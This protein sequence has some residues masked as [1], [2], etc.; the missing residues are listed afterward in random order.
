MALGIRK[1]LFILTISI[2]IIAVATAA[3]LTISIIIK[4]GKQTAEEYRQEEMTRVRN[5]VRDYIEMAYQSVETSYKSIDDKEYLEKF[6]GHRLQSIMDIAVA[7]LEKRAQQ[8]D[9]HKLTLREAQRQAIDEIEAM[10]FDNR[11]GYIWVNDTTLPYPKMIMHPTVP[12]L[13]GNYLTDPKFNCAMGKNQNLFQ[14]AVEV[15]TASGSGFV[16]Y[17]WP[18][19]NA[20]GLS[21]DVK[22]LSYVYHFKPWGWVLGTGI[23]LDDAQND[24]VNG[25]LENLKTLKYNNGQ[26]YFWVN[27]MELPYPRMVMHPTVPS[28]DGK[29]LNDTSFNCAKGT[30]QNFFQLMVQKATKDGEG[31]V[32]YI[33]PNPVTKK[34][35]AKL[36]YVKRFAPLNWMIG[37][38]AFVNHIES[39]IQAK[40]NEI[41]G[42]VRNIIWITLA[43]SVVLIAIG[44]FATAY[45]ANS[46]THAIIVVRDSLLKLSKGKIIDKLDVKSD[47]EIGVMNASLNSLVDG[48]NAYATFAREIGTGNLDAEFK[49]LSEDD[50]L[51][52]SLIQM[53]ESL[54]RI[55]Q[56]EFERK[57]HAEGVTFFNDL[58]RKHNDNLKE[59][60]NHLVAQAARY[61]NANQC[62]L[63]L[64][65]ADRITDEPYLE[66]YACYA[67]DRNKHLTQRIAIGE[68]VIGQAVI[69]KNYIYLTQVPK[70]FVRITSGLGA[71][72]PT[73]VIIFPLIYNEEVQ[74]VIEI[75]SF[76][77]LKPYE[78]EFLRKV[79]ESIAASISSTKTA[80]RTRMLLEETKQMSEEMKA[81]EEELRQNNE[82]LQATQEE[83]MRKLSESERS[84]NDR[85]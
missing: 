53:R 28:L 33:W 47:N 59:L 83:M 82:E 5:S 56:E 74:G 44:Y 40:E 84:K 12:A 69:E 61:L 67:Y 31:Y 30:G 13:N 14:A 85:P 16:N 62:A 80:E 46:I 71:A 43:I 77:K 66:L 54:K 32:E 75:A 37:T 73:A 27:D 68:G 1:Q 24:V 45:M 70:D 41:Q 2:L 25:I 29:I 39:R 65:E 6:Y 51:G 79:S 76:E 21:Q 15:S 81:Q 10:R 52:N 60:C 26:G 57:W 34:R 7:T 8:V 19:P 48:V 72:T 3:T 4:Q 36:S 11:T 22:K 18:K 78:I 50:A 35:E 20:N 55:N 42:R 17:I 9:D 64:M 58:I 38:G 49:A 63:Y 23:Y